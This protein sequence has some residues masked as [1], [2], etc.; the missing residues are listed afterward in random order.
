MTQPQAPPPADSGAAH[1]AAGASDP[2]LSMLMAMRTKGRQGVTLR[3]LG[4]KAPRGV[5]FGEVTLEWAR[6]GILRD[7]EGR[8]VGTYQRVVEFGGKDGD[9]QEITAW[10]R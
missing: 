9:V 7:S 2:Q 5:R 10:P 6:H 8:D 1:E 4:T 3:W